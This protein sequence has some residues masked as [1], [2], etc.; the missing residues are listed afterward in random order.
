MII[1]RDSDGSD[2]GTV[3]LLF[4]VGLVGGAILRALRRSAMF[5]N[6]ELA[7]DWNVQASHDAAIVRLGQ[8]IRGTPSSRVE[9]VWSAGRCGFGSEYID[10]ERELEVYKRFLSAFSHLAEAYGWRMSGTL[11]SSAG[12][13]YEGQRLIDAQSP[14]LPK[15]PYGEL[16]LR[17]EMYLLSQRGFSRV[18][19]V[20]PSS[21]YG[22]IRAGF[23]LGL[24]SALV[25]NVLENRETVI[26]G[27]PVTLRDFIF[28]DDLGRFLAEHL[29]RGEQHTGSEVLVLAAAKPSSILEITRVVEQLTC[30]RAYVRYARDPS[31][32]ED[33]SYAES[34]LPA[35]WRPTELREGVR[36]V[37]ASWYSSRAGY[38]EVSE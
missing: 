6:E 17:Q 34:I 2:T 3:I 28:A 23:R 12:G 4:G 35:G 21:V 18:T 13:L 22:A 14:A 11:I 24:I 27:R 20:R 19:I 9:V 37:V 5:W 8:I 26:F 7:I 32:W 31:N 16:K 33:M 25:R 1:L 36:R 29:L 38:E 15:R 10:T 30:R